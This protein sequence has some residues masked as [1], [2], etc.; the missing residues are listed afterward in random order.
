[1]GKIQIRMAKPRIATHSGETAA[2]F[3]APH[4]TKRIVVGR[5]LMARIAR[6]RATYPLCCMCAAKGITRA[7]QFVDH[8]HALEDG[9][10]DVDEN[11]WGLCHDCHVLKTNGEE[12]RRRVCGDRSA[13]LAWLPPRPPELEPHAPAMA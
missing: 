7:F 3:V 5:K 4:G 11:C 1:M 6:F 10:P 13:P 8:R 9:G 12:E 2:V